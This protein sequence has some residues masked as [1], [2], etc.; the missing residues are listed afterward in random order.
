MERGQLAIIEAWHVAVHSG[1]RV[2]AGEL[3]TGDVEVGG[4]RGSGHGR[5]IVVDWVGHA[6]IQLTPVR[7]YCGTAGAAVEQ[8]ACWADSATGALSAPMRLA[9]AFAVEA[10]RISRI[11]RHA[12][13]ARA[14]AA[15]GL[16]LADEVVARR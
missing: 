13:L 12:E 10:G 14:L 16:D 2:Q 15:L 6:G 8:D 3:C 9:T 1:D 7:W 11:L 5:D 4:P